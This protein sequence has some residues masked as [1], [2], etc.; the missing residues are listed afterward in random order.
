[1]DLIIRIVLL[2]INSYLISILVPIQLVI[3]VYLLLNIN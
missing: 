1:M 2:M 3:Y